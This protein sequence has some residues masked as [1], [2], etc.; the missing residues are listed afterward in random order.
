MESN[1]SYRI[2]TE[3]GK[4]ETYKIDVPL[5]QTYDMFEILSLKLNQNNQYKFYDADY[6]VLVG[7]VLANKGFGIPNAK[8]SI[9]IEVDSNES[10][11]RKILYGFTS[12]RDTNYNGVRYNLLPDFVDNACHQDVGTFP[13]K[14]L[15]L[16]NKDVLE[17]F[18]KY[19]K[20]TTTTNNSGDYM[21]YGVP[22]GMQIL[23]VDVD[24]SDIGQLSQRPRDMVYK[25][26][27]INQFESPNKFKQSTNL[28][29]LAQIYSQDK[30]VYVYPYWGNSNNGTEHIGITRCDINIDYT[31]EPTAIFIG[32]VISDK[33]SNSINQKCTANKNAGRMS[34]LIAGEGDI[35]MIRKTVDNKVE[36]FSIKGNRLIDG[37][38]VWCYQIPMNLDYVMTNEFGETVPTDDPSKGIPTRA[39]VRFRISMD[40]TINDNVTATNRCKYLVPNNPRLN[41]DYP[42]FNKTKEVDYEFG[43][44]TQDENYKDLFWNCVYTVKNYIPRLQK[45]NKQTNRQH[46]GI[47]WINHG[48]NVNQMPYNSLTIKLGFLYRLICV[49]TKVIIN[50]IEFINQLV[51]FVGAIFGFIKNIVLMP[52]KLFGKIPLVGG[53]LK[54]IWN[55]A[56]KPIT[57]I[58]D[59]FIPPCIGLNSEFC[60][61]G[62]NKITYFPGCGKLFGNISK[63]PDIMNS[64]WKKTVERHNKTEQELYPDKEEYELQSSEPVNSTSM[65]YT[66]IENQL[67]QD[68]DVTSFNF[69]NDWIN[70]VLYMPLWYRK[71][72]P[73]RSYLFGL[74]KKK[75]KDQWCSNNINYTDFRILQTCSLDRKRGQKYSNLDNEKVYEYTEVD[76]NCKKKCHDSKTEVKGNNGVVVNKTTL[77]NQTVYYYKS[78]EY[79]KVKEKIRIFFATDI[80]LLGSL[81]DCDINGIPQFFKNLTS[82]T[83]IL[84]ND[85][86]FTDNT[87]QIVYKEDGTVEYS[88]L[89]KVSTET[90][91]DWGNLGEDQCEN[92]TDGGLF[93]GIGCSTIEISSKSCINL[94][95]ICELG[96]QKD[97]LSEIGQDQEINLSPDGYVSYDE[98]Y[99]A[100]IRAIFATMNA[101]N[102]KT[103]LDNKT[104][105]K[106][107]DFFYLY[108]SNFDGSLKSIME[109]E[110][111][112]CNK[113]YKNNYRLEIFNSD[114]YQFR[115]G[116]ENYFYN[117]GG[118]ENEKDLKSFPLFDNSF[119]FYFGLNSGKTAI[120]K[121]NEQ[122]FATCESNDNIESSLSIV[123]ENTNSW[124]DY[125]NKN[126]GAKV[127]VILKNINLPCDIIIDN[128]STKDS[129]LIESYDKEEI[130]FDK[131]IEG[132]NVNNKSEEIMILSDGNYRL[133]ITDKDG[134]ISETVFSLE[135]VE[136]TYNIEIVDFNISNN[137]IDK[138]YSGNANSIEDVD[139]RIS[140]GGYFKIKDIYQ[141]NDEL[142]NYIINVRSNDINYYFDPIIISDVGTETM[143]AVP[144]GDCDYIVTVNMLCDCNESDNSVEKI[145]S[146]NQAP[147]VKLYINDIDY[148][149][150]SE[151]T[152]IE[153]T[154][155]SNKEN[156]KW[157]FY[158][159]INDYVKNIYKII[160][161]YAVEPDKLSNTLKSEIKDIIVKNSTNKIENLIED[162][163]FISTISN[164][165]IK[166]DIKNVLNEWSIVQD[167]IVTQVKKAFSIVCN[168]NPVSLTLKLKS[169]DTPISYKIEGY[170]EELEYIEVSEY[171]NEEI[172]ILSSNKS[173]VFDDTN[174]IDGIIIP[175]ITSSD[176]EFSKRFYYKNDAV[177]SNPFYYAKDYQNGLGSQYT[178][179]PYMISVKDSG[180]FNC[181]NFH[182]NFID[183]FFDVDML[184]WATMINIPY[185]IKDDDNKKGKFIN[186]AGFV[187]AEIL[188]GTTTSRNGNI[189]NFE[190]QLVDPFDIKII[191]VNSEDNIPTKRYI[192]EDIET[193]FLYLKN[194][195]NKFLKNND[196]NTII[197]IN[198]ILQFYI[199]NIEKYGFKDSI[200]VI[201]VLAEKLESI[202]EI[203][204]S[205][206]YSNDDKITKLIELIG[207][208][209]NEKQSDVIDNLILILRDSGM[210]EI[211]INL[212]KYILDIITNN[213]FYWNYKINNNVNLKNYNTL[214]CVMPISTNLLF[215]STIDGCE[216]NNTTGSLMQINLT[217]DSIEGGE[218]GNKLVFSLINGN[219][220][221]YNYYIFNVNK[222]YP[223]N[224]VIINDFG[225]CYVDMEKTPINIFNKDVDFN[226]EEYLWKLENT[227]KSI[228]DTTSDEVENVFNIN[229]EVIYI[230]VVSSDNNRCISAV[231]DYSPITKFGIEL[232]Q[233]NFYNSENKIENRY[234]LKLINFNTYY[235]Q[236]YKYSS[237]N[238]SIGNINI[239][240]EIIDKT[241]FDN[242]ID[243]I[244]I[245]NPLN[246]IEI[247][248][249][250]WS[251]LKD[252][253][254]EI[255]DITGLK[256]ITEA[257]NVENE[258]NDVILQHYVEFIYNDIEFTTNEEET[259]INGWKKNGDSIT[260]PSEDNNGKTVQWFDI[261]N[262]VIENSNIVIES[263][264]KYKA[265]LKNEE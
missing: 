255:T 211:F 91:C 217:E 2:R 77:S 257:Y 131:I 53:V 254:L 158:Q 38:G 18:E 44:A 34:E 178:K 61:D 88:N 33:G 192:V 7:R 162:I 94:S 181:E 220:N 41:S 32:S 182:V 213:G 132:K 245:K 221:L 170:N 26:Y 234:E 226:K 56:M 203:I 6:G 124:C 169:N 90:G 168:D 12:T 104:G 258:N 184:S 173:E 204:Y 141:D 237:F 58:L 179:K 200:T 23:H 92:S 105:Y 261:N 111:S 130:I 3:V 28:N 57:I 263:P 47:K 136:L 180:N 20:Y 242:I 74:I 133:S 176:T 70:G 161:T 10:I 265:I 83:Y 225:L 239:N 230:I 30:G 229:N 233:Y 49:I 19:Y 14:R 114:Y 73:K 116:Q 22:T 46:T 160:E 75:P 89:D 120:E 118:N 60:D 80:V 196:E 250:D 172:H 165:K 252:I 48:D 123:I 175:T 11:D 163:T 87:R 189:T 86:L 262:D 164:D 197:K 66:C 214:S 142:Q 147:V 150:I 101:N 119:Y 154:Q 216:F 115:M 102:L 29:S 223:L 167:N 264:Q 31:F 205:K 109:A 108:P 198:T 8:I 191:S 117:G 260:L 79:D 215:I 144:Y 17:V 199:K 240:D 235:L 96:V 45:N 68:N 155:M 145:V 209:I 219:S 107:Y 72:T 128:L 249:Y 218:A 138:K 69:Y 25:G 63:F 212:S 202:T 97:V 13:N 210:I 246:N 166:E 190:V 183:K 121:F 43:S 36:E 193:K 188:N 122:F 256:H 232:I 152:D 24:L 99:G 137:E 151:W 1:R 35:E 207:K 159:D 174:E 54:A 227:D 59:L 51:S 78:V 247:L 146:I 5:T 81:N 67:A 243:K 208:T 253:K 50:L 177:I 37:D 39:R 185:Y 16:D 139:K 224:N 156:Y 113:T 100:N 52:G 40:N 55:T 241:I 195:F 171:E 27:N 153:W 238:L 228:I 126:F 4:D 244:A 129:I 85:I 9:F 76:N 222:N 112:K 62:V 135:K 194:L 103:K 64:V 134:N 84:P 93:Y 186:M 42:V 231:F 187:T 110:Q 157:E 21:I 259:L 125:D 201:K 148:D 236:N 95:R 82:T 127:V 251:N 206:E 71:I 248:Y 106:K 143:I 149:L 140:I 15:V 98:L 65:L